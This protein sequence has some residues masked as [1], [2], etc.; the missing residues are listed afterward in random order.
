MSVLVETLHAAEFIVSEAT[1]ARGRSQGILAAGNDL[2]TGTVLGRLTKNTVAVAKISGT[3]VATFGAVTLGPNALPGVYLLTCTAAVNGGTPAVFSVTAPNGF[4][5]PDLSAASTYT[6]SHI[7]A[8]AATIPAGTTAW[9]PGDKIGITVS[10]TGAYTKLNLTAVNGAADAAAILFSPV[11]AS[12]GAL[13]CVVT[14]SDTIVKGALLT[15]PTGISPAQKAA[16][17]QQLAARGIK[18]AA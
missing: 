5:L 18:L 1:D 7:N 16:A 4:A 9:A 10:G 15:W 12:E 14:D 6:S 2:D 8:V 3:G 17:I 11:D 13:P